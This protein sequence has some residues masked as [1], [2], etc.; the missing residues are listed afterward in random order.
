[1]VLR[2]TILILLIAFQSCNSQSTRYKVIV[3]NVEGLETGSHVIYEGKTI[4]FVTDMDL[5]NDS[6]IVYFTLNKENR[7]RRGS[8]FIVQHPVLGV[9]GL[10][11]ESSNFRDAMTIS[12]TAR[13]Y[14]DTTRF[15]FGADTAGARKRKEAIRKIMEG[16]GEF[17]EAT[18]DSSK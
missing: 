8:K 3:D 11:V 18:K 9:S 1:M 7:I 12:D 16:V 17:I 4:G 10:Y 6:V 2:L 5:F 13:G 15:S 14:R